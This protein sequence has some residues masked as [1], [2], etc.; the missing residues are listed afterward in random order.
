MAV[1]PGVA[2]C[3]APN[4]M[5]QQMASPDVELRNTKRPLIS[6]ALLTGKFSVFPAMRRATVIPVPPPPDTAA[7]A[8]EGTPVPAFATPIFCGNPLA[9]MRAMTDAPVPP[10]TAMVGLVVN[11]VLP[12]TKQRIVDKRRRWTEIAR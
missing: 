5:D 2:P 11:P 3:V 8:F 7:V 4:S 10:V 12:S 6:T 9:S 1:V